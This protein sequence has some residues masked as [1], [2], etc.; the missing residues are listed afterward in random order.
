[1]LA[2]ADGEREVELADYFTG[3]RTSVR[4]PDELIRAVRIPLPLAGLTAFHKI[5]KRR[6]D[7][8]S[9]V[10][11][12]FALDHR[13]GGHRPARPHRAR[14]A[15]PPR[16]SG[17]RATEAALVG[18]PWSPETV[19]R[20]RGVAAAPRAPRWTITAPAPR[21]RVAM[22]RQS[23]LKL[24][25]DN[26][27]IAAR[28]EPRHEPL[29]HERERSMS[30]LASAAGE[31]GGRAR[32]P[33]RER[34]AARHRRRP[35]HRRPGPPHQGRAA[36]LPGA[37]AARARAGHALDTAP[38]LAVP[39][40]VRVLTAA[41][42]PGVNDAGVK[43]DEPLFPTR[44]HV[45]RPRGLLG[46][47]RDAR[48]RAARRGGGRGRRRAAAVLRDASRE[49]IAAGSFQGGQPQV[50]RGD[51]DAG[52]GRGRPRVQRRVRVRRPGALLPRDA[53]RAGP[54]RRG[55]A[56]LRPEQHAAPLRDAGDRRPRAGPRQLTRSPSSACGWAAASAA[57]R[58]SRTASPRSPRSAPSSPAGRC[59]CGSTAPRT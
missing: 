55:R 24:Y 28:E 1:M 11:V 32:G 36:R 41:D 6:F 42:V 47:R 53:R 49:A 54:G 51:V 20:G 17:P 10:A 45:L 52:T 50:V 16:R 40:V 35:L 29:T 21:Y 4:R 7:D 34:G 38:A 30:E 5:A 56:G 13:R 9:S 39:G 27:G 15:W 25:A 57:R 46:A 44:D 8:I 12:A 33:A 48:G 19:A 2:G 18:R 59:G 43:H 14:R 37:D 22:L 23:L 26:P 31:P 58:C 3:Y